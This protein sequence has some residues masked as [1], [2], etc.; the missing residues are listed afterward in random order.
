[1]N[2][3]EEGRCVLAL[4]LQAAAAGDVPVLQKLLAELGS[5]AHGADHR[6]WTA[7]HAAAETGQ[8]QAIEV[9]LAA[10]A[11]VNAV[12]YHPA[13][14]SSLEQTPLHLATLGRHA[15]VVQQPLAAGAVADAADIDALI[16]L[17]I[18]AAAGDSHLVKLLL[19][20]GAWVDVASYDRGR[21]LCIAAEEGYPTVVRQ[22]LAA[23]A[24]AT[25]A[26]LRVATLHSS[27][28]HTMIAEELLAAGADPQTSTIPSYLV[29]TKP[30]VPSSCTPLQQAAWEDNVPMVC[31]LLAQSDA[32]PAPADRIRNLIGALVEAIK[33]GSAS[34]VELIA[35]GALATEDEQKTAM[36]AAMEA[37]NSSAV[38]QLL[39]A[40][41]SPNIRAGLD[42]EPALH[43]P[44]RYY[45]D[46]VSC[47]CCWQQG[48]TQQC[49][50]EHTFI[51]SCYTCSRSSFE[52]HTVGV[53]LHW[54]MLLR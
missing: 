9:L 42:T 11:D 10:G 28:V 17:H 53:G 14:D 25:G 19:N 51:H 6:G 21:P 8:E 15:A 31:R 36:L 48:Q 47:S 22:L 13:C 2:K 27:P 12:A 41:V 37:K 50:T 5:S 23:G 30:D 46:V 39:A 54:A 16:P 52:Q 4:L 40:G 34:C 38:K 7:L 35:A 1:L 43:L 3:P 49:S 24:A 45:E 44:I 33:Y 29:A 20:A 32:H 26:P 18:A